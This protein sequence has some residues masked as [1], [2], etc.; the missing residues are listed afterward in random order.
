M[1]P[2]VDPRRVSRLQAVSR[3]ASALAVAGGGAVLVGWQLD[4]AARTSIL[5]GRVAMNPVTA[6]AFMLTAVAL[7]LSLPSASPRSRRLGRAARVT[8]VVVALIGAVTLAGYAFGA[9]VGLDQ[10]LFR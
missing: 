2:V 8:G 1:K 5:P 4:V 6:L 7:W 10:L 9:N 3:A